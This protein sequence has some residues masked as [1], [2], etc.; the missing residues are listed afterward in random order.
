MAQTEKETKTY[1][2]IRETF[3]LSKPK[4]QY[5]PIEERT[6]IQYKILDLGARMM[7]LHLSRLEPLTKR[8]RIPSAACELGDKLVRQLAIEHYQKHINCAQTIKTKKGR[9]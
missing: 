5:Y 7:C 2:V 6:V 1:P 8:K 4:T 3:L 9:L